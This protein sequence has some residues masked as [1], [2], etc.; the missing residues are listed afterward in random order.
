MYMEKLRT[1]WLS[2][3]GGFKYQGSNDLDNT[4]YTL[5]FV[6]SISVT[7]SS[8]FFSDNAIRILIFGTACLAA[9]PLGQLVCDLVD[10]YQR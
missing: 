10:G 5:F 7:F 4:V 2:P 8:L 1:S 9:S 6:L 3:P